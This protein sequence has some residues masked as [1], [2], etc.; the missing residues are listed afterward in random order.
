MIH[1][2]ENFISR[3]DSSL[4][5]LENVLLFNSSTYKEPTTN[6]IYFLIENF[7]L[8][9]IIAIE[10]K[11]GEDIF[12]ENR[13]NTFLDE[14][15]IKNA[16]LNDL[17]SKGHQV[18]KINNTQD[19]Y[20]NFSFV[21][22]SNLLPLFSN[23]L[24]LIKKIGIGK[25]EEE[26]EC[27]LNPYFFGF[28]M[29]YNIHMVSALSQINKNSWLAQGLIQ[30]MKDKYGIEMGDIFNYVGQEFYKGVKLG[31]ERHED[32]D[33]SFIKTVFEI[34]GIPKI[35]IFKE[36]IFKPAV[37]KANVLAKEFSEVIE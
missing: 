26:H 1:K 23:R 18:T 15:S 31:K 8:N 3:T 24:F 22:P 13:L 37:H 10:N 5:E 33:A 16:L 20:E 19:L 9:G 34:S 14:D 32:N 25:D 30:I 17:R 35:E 12:R 28:L 4:D 2:I 21:K 36:I 27:Y 29:C 11:F 6:Y 7:V